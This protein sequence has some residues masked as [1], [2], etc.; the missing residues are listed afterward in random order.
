ML[1]PV[2]IHYQCY[3][4]PHYPLLASVRRCDTYALNLKA[5]WTRF[6][7]SLP[8]PEAQKILIAGCGTFSPYPFSV[9][10]PGAAITAIDI[11]KRSLNRARL[12]CLLHG[13]RN[14][15]FLCGDI[16]EGITIEGT[17]GLIDSYGV[18]HHLNDPVAGLKTLEKHLMPNGIIRIMLYSRYARRD[19][20]AIRHALRL[21][22]IKTPAAARKLLR[23]ARPGS[24]LAHYLSVA[25]EIRTDSGIADALLHPRVWTYRID[26]LLDMIAQTGLQPLLFAHVDARENLR[27]EID[28]LRLLEKERCSPG[29][30]ILYLGTAPDNTPKTGKDSLLV[31]NPCLS[32]AVSR[33]TLGTIQIPARTGHANP[34]LGQSE[35]S[36]LRRFAKP[37]R[38]STLS[39]DLS[40]MVDSYKRRLFLLE[41]RP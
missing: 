31:L 14:L 7:S 30:F 28:R 12:H 10:N 5:L 16:Q 37:V 39:S 18:L 17:F 20:E 34:A 38:R 23:R 11:S 35:R 32:S 13:R 15:D 25:D 21:L 6:N 22:D 33:L 2:Q 8:P 41:Y 27:E 19:E 1:N 29:N 4:Y 24:R 36:F 40:E 3:P 26:E 9:A